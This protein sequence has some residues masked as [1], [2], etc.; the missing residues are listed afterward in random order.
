MV[1]ATSTI[2]VG[3]KFLSRIR[4]SSNLSSYPLVSGGPRSVCSSIRRRSSAGIDRN[5]KAFLTSGRSS[6]SN[7]DFSYD[8]KQGISNRVD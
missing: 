3:T 7:L 4:I 2:I 1:R 5:P 6:D 8:P